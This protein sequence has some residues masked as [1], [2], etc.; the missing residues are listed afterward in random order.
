MS[1][2][3]DQC[4]YCGEPITDDMLHV[5]EP[6]GAVRHEGCCALWLRERLASM[7]RAAARPPES[8]DEGRDL[9]E[10][11]RGV[12]EPFVKA[13]DEVEH[14]PA[15]AT[16]SE[17]AAKVLA[18]PVDFLHALARYGDVYG[19]QDSAERLREIA[20]EFVALRRKYTQEVA[21]RD[22]EIDR[23]TR[24]RDEEAS[25]Q[26]VAF[27]MYQKERERA[28]IADAEA[29]A[30]AARQ[31]DAIVARDEQIVRLM[32]E[33]DE[34]R[35][36]DVQGHCD[37]E[38]SSA[39]ERADAAEARVRELRSYKSALTLEDGVTLPSG[40]VVEDIQ[41]GRVADLVRIADAAR[42]HAPLILA[43]LKSRRASYIIEGEIPTG[44]IDAL[45]WARGLGKEGEE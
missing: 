14:L 41:P 27:R 29:Q 44:L 25:G 13:V 35:A 4:A 28:D 34:A 11:L 24:D 8:R 5:T 21:K 2:T 43:A 16:G 26:R 40:A 1:A 3:G 38:I 42:R 32:R 9:L 17:S 7:K 12:L 22:V 36:F 10:T 45:A 23:L 30:A 31:R 33:R 39:V 6:D 18:D 37:A 20:D 19:S 15:E